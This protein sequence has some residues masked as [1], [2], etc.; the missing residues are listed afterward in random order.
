MCAICHICTDRIISA[1]LG[2]GVCMEGPQASWL[3]LCRT[4]PHCQT[5]NSHILASLLSQYLTLDVRA[6]ALLPPPLAPISMLGQT[7][8]LFCFSF[9]QHALPNFEIGGRGEDQRSFPLH[10]KLSIVQGWSN[11]D[12]QRRGQ[13]GGQPDSR[14]ASQP[15]AGC[16]R[17]L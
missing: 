14:P 7:A 9:S 10:L 1:L 13:T 6:N 5:E 15:D 16:I 12:T 8:G 17:Q 2:S 4:W 11:P 3:Q